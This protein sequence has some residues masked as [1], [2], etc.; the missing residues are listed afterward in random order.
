MGIQHNVLP[1]SEKLNTQQSTRQIKATI[2][3]CLSPR[4]TMIVPC[5]IEQYEYEHKHEHEYALEHKH[6]TGRV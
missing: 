2:K 3:V 4:T 6:K 5:C 1:V